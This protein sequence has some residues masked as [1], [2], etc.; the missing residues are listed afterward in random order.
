MSLLG[1]EIL[2]LYQEKKK[3]LNSGGYLSVE[4]MIWLLCSSCRDKRSLCTLSNFSSCLQQRRQCLCKFIARSGMYYA[5][6]SK[7]VF[8]RW[9]RRRKLP[10][11]GFFPLKLRVNCY[12]LLILDK[13]LETEF[14][15]GDWLKESQVCGLSCKS[16]KTLVHTKYWP[17]NYHSYRNILSK[18]TSQSI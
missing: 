1:R 9:Y 14:C 2:D 17:S 18:T 12:S 8:W 4:I 11:Q 6:F 16:W 13:E 3:T 10:L 15:K 5:L 7:N